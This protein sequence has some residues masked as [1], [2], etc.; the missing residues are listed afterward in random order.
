MVEERRKGG[1]VAERKRQMDRDEV[2]ALCLPWRWGLL[3]PTVKVAA[4]FLP[5]DTDTTDRFQLS[6]Q[7]NWQRVGN[8]QKLFRKWG[9]N[10]LTVPFLEMQSSSDGNQPR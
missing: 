8:S 9:S 7:M 1:G 4:I 6:V 10:Q 5:H 2:K 3:F